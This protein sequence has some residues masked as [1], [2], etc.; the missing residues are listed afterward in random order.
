[1]EGILVEILPGVHARL[2]ARSPAPLAE[3]L[4]ETGPFGSGKPIRPPSRELSGQF[5]VI[6]YRKVEF[7]AAQDPD[8]RIRFLRRFDFP[9]GND[10]YS[11]YD[12]EKMLG[13]N[14]QPGNTMG[15]HSRGS[16]WTPLNEYYQLPND[17]IEFD[18][19]LRQ[20]LIAEQQQYVDS[21][22]IVENALEFAFE[23]TRFYDLMRFALR[24]SNP[25]QYMADHIYARRGKANAAEVAAEVAAVSDPRNWYL[26]WKGQI[27]MK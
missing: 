27:G 9:A 15:M 2:I 16:G 7:S 1:M 13:L 18:D 8:D 21:L 19:V 22:L 10:R 11:I 23:G 4:N 12:V 6:E 25:G 17:T 20:Q 24:S 5:C 14:T 3:N 26:S